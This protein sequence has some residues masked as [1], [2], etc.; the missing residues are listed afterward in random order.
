MPRPP[1]A[2]FELWFDFASTY[3][4]VAV[5]R[6]EREAASY[7]APISWRP[8]LLGPLFQSMYGTSDSPFNLQAERGAYMWRDLE[9]LC[10]TFGIPWR[11]P[12]VFPRRS[13][14]AARVALLVHSEPWAPDFIRGVFRANFAENADIADAAVIASILSNLGQPASD[15]LA[16]AQTEEH[17]RA[18]HA[19]N[20]CARALH[21]FGAPNFVVGEELFFG[22]DRLQ[23]ALLFWSAGA[24]DLCQ[25]PFRGLSPEQAKAFAERWLPAWTG[26]DPDRLLSFYATEAFYADPHVKAGIE[27]KDAL[28]RYFARLL[29]RYPAWLWTQT[30]S[31]PMQGG[32]VNLWHAKVPREHSTVEL[33]GVC[34]VWLRGDKIIRNEVFFDPQLLS[35][36]P[37]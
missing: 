22:Q 12:S 9:R 3:S 21:L 33:D 31:V 36:P 25:C 23:D 2:A 37:A 14:L 8:F 4:F 11:K 6:A 17:K 35:T 24:S 18:L 28:R 20:D 29:A 13:L 34:L 30:R 26:N 19:Q 5:E 16:A 7:G 27:G 15:L 1:G 32:F 10:S